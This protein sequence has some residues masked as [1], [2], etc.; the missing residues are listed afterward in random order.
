MSV[1]APAALA[2]LP[3]RASQPDPKVVAVD[4]VLASKFKD[5]PL[6]FGDFMFKNVVFDHEKNYLRLANSLLLTDEMGATD[7]HQGETLTSGVQ[8][9]KIFQL[10][11]ADAHGAELF[12]FGSAKEIVVNGKDL[13]AI[14]KLVST[15]WS[16]AQIPTAY[17]Q[18]GKN[19][20]IFKGPGSLLVEP[21]KKPGHSLK[22]TDG[23]K[24]WSKEGL[25]GKANQEGEYLVRLRLGKFAPSGSATSQV[26]DLWQ[27]G[28]EKVVAPRTLTYITRNDTAQLEKHK[29]SNCEAFVRFGGSPIPNEK[30]W[31]KWIPLDKKGTPLE[32]I[33][34]QRRWAQ[35]KLE[36]TT[37]RGTLFTPRISD[38]RLHWELA[39]ESASDNNKYTV[40]F[41]PDTRYLLSSTPFVYQAPSPR[42]KHLREHYK[43]D[44]VIAPGKTELEQLMLLRYWVRNQWHTAWGNHPAAWMP[45]WDAL[46]ILQNRDQPDCLTMCT[47]YAAVYTQCCLALGWNARHCILDHHCVAEVYM[48]D[49]DKWVMMDAGNSAE[50]ADV[51]L[52]FERKAVPLSARELHLIQKSGQTADVEVCFTSTKLAAKIAA[53]C[54]PAPPSKVKYPPLPDRTTVKELPKYPVCGLENYRRYAFPPRNNYLDTLLPG[55]LYQGWAEYFYDGYCWVGD[56]SD[57]PTISPEYSIHLDPTRPHEA[58]WQLNWTQVYLCRT[59]KPGQLRVDLG[60]MTPNFLQFERT[61]SGDKAGTV[62]SPESSFLWQLQPGS[63]TLTVCSVNHWNRK[64]LPMQVQVEMKKV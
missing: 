13:P 47:H 32:K 52:H 54:R 59:D 21:S 40:T 39:E 53:L 9:K 44:Q 2:A 45:P 25:T 28:K 27:V 37:A 18:A 19:E 38:L 14:K 33:D 29:W 22:S 4:L 23:G 8:A 43:L 3:A 5:P 41:K 30:N 36:L 10:E 15:G 16:R 48:N 55:E 61:V 64:G 11:A 46:M 12:F 42:L 6:R 26:I 31:S 51:G 60:T 62:K 63:N 20:I 34:A 35:I 49:F 50:R 58:D 24:T 57:N 17:L 56:S 1:L 7:Y